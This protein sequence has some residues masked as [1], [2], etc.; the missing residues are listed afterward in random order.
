MRKLYIA[1]LMLGFIV[2]SSGV[3]AMSIADN[4]AVI[5][6]VQSQ[7][8]FESQ[9]NYTITPTK[10]AGEFQISWTVNKNTD[11]DKCIGGTVLSCSSLATKYSVNTTQL[12]DYPVSKLAGTSV[13]SASKVDTSLGTGSITI[14]NLKRG[15]TLKLGFNSTVIIAVSPLDNPGNVNN[16][17]WWTQ[18]LTYYNNDNLLNVTLAMNATTS[19]T[20]LQQ[21]EVYLVSSDAGGNAQITNNLSSGFFTVAGAAIKNYTANMSAYNVTA[22]TKYFILVNTTNTGSST[23]NVFRNNADP[24]PNGSAAVLNPP[25]SWNNLTDTED[26]VMS[27]GF[28]TNAI[29]SPANYTIIKTVYDSPV[30]ELTSNRIS[31][32]LNTTGNVT[33]VVAILHYSNINYTTTVTL[34]GTV[35]NFTSL[36]TAPLIS[37]STALIN[38]NLTYN[39]TLVNGTIEQPISATS[40]QNVTQVGL[41]S[42]CG[43]TDTRILNLSLVDEETNLPLSG[44]NVT[45]DG[46][47][48]NANVLVYLNS[49]A[50]LGGRNY[51]FNFSSS[52]SYVICM[53]GPSSQFRIDADIIYLNTTY[54]SNSRWYYFR[55]LSVSNATKYYNLYLLQASVAT[56]VPILLKSADGISIASNYIVVALRQLIAANNTYVPVAMTLTSSSS[57]QNGDFFLRTGNAVYQF[58]MY[59]SYGNLINT[60][61]PTTIAGPQVGNVLASPLS[62]TLGSASLSSVIGSILA[63]SKNC[64]LSGSIFTCNYNDSTQQIQVAWLTVMKVGAAST[65]QVC[66]TNGLTTAGTLMCNITSSGNGSYYYQL[67]GYFP[68]KS[69][70]GSYWNVLD[71]GSFFVGQTSPYGT[72]GLMFAVILIIMFAMIGSFNPVVTVF[73]GI[74]AM[75]IS[76]A[77]GMVTISQSTLIGIVA[78][79]I[80]IAIKVRG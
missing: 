62:L 30:T 69:I 11:L 16:A 5:P 27:I 60:V 45:S 28:G 20:P 73:M 71:D 78:I 49:K 75:G 39:V 37:A 13:L 19:T 52:N 18:S 40:Q 24:Y 38:F 77:F 46:N 15:D 53:Q 50:D 1:I 3:Q 67:G 58:Q 74:A 65:T 57:T 7:S 80:I 76:V 14:S 66:R 36:V 34:S 54:Y 17:A 9:F 22:G 79:G 6:I 32:L 35:Y 31:Y 64:G 55:N 25:S 59:D 4:N 56:E 41:Q 29:A 63:T 23:T 10:N 8:G 43:A 12:K 33:S 42:E 21:I 51:S 70:G 2:L 61:S 26:L 48:M 47:R 44:V 68:L 72:E